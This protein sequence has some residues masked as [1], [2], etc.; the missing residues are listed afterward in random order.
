MGDVVTELSK[1]YGRGH[2]LF[3]GA[4]PR[5]KKQNLMYRRRVGSTI[6]CMF[7]HLRKIRYAEKVRKGTFKHMTK[8][9]RAALRSL[10]NKIDH[11]SD[12]VPESQEEP[13]APKVL[14]ASTVAALGE[15]MC[16]KGKCKFLL[17]KDPGADKSSATAGTCTVQVGVG[18]IQAPNQ[19]EDPVQHLRAKLL[20]ALPHAFGSGSAD[21]P[22]EM[23]E[24][25]S[26]DACVIPC[27]RGGQKN[28][29]QAQSSRRT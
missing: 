25:S 23:F 29:T 8:S 3:G 20:G 13:A 14:T 19:H 6:H 9:E 11:G 4:D 5:D 27:Q 16:P 18:L 15:G 17:A 2:A 1:Q 12:Q 21:V 28:G 10:A 26:K 22:G 7:S 24:E